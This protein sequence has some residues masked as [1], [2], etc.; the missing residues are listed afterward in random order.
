MTSVLV[1][2]E[3]RSRS[4]R[5]Y[6]DETTLVLGVTGTFIAGLAV[7]FGLPGQV[8]LPGTILAAL[9]GA[10]VLTQLAR[11]AAERKPKRSA[12]VVHPPAPV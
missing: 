6:G 10:V 8:G 7:S 1:C 12:D 4:S 3:Q 11:A 2:G 5:G 9:T